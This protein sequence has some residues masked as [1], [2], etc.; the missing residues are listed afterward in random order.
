M[1]NK[2]L[3]SIDHKQ[4]GV[5]ALALGFVLVF[6]ALGKLGFLQ[7]FLNIIM[8]FVGAYLLFWGLKQTNLLQAVKNLRS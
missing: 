3:K 7:D 2:L 8:I 6:G 5:I 1:I 4:Q